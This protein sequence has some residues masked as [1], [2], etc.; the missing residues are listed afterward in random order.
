MAESKGFGKAQP[1]KEKGAFSHFWV[2]EGDVWTFDNKGSGAIKP[3]KETSRYKSGDTDEI[4]KAIA[5]L[6]G[7]ADGFYKFGVHAPG[8]DMSWKFDELSVATKRSIN[9]TK[10]MIASK[11]LEKTAAQQDAF[12]AP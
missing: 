2:V 7:K 3:S 1:K 11:Q 4:D 9:A 10:N 6:S 8:S 12:R 5:E